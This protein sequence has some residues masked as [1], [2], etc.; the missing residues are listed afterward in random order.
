M[1]QKPDPQPLSARRYRLLLATIFLFLCLLLGAVW[2]V[3]RVIA[4]EGG[5]QEVPVSLESSLQ[6][7]YLADALPTRPSISMALIFEAMRDW[8]PGLDLERRQTAV[9]ASLQTPVP[10]A[11]SFIPTATPLPTATPTATPSPTPTIDFPQNNGSGFAPVDAAENEAT[12]TAAA[13]TIE[14]ELATA[15]AMPTSAEATPSPTATILPLQ[16][17]LP[18]TTATPTAFPTDLPTP[19]PTPT[20]RA[21]SAAPPAT[22]PAATNVPTSTAPTA[23]TNAPIETPTAPTATPLVPTAT[24]NVPTPPPLP[25]S[26]PPPLPTATQ[27]RP[28]PTPTNSAYP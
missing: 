15:V 6:A 13:A 2:F 23:T 7:N 12:S 20:D 8:E 11:A 16:P 14:S 1:I 22:V 5:A 17:T 10:T 25:T 28:E 26:T 27:E 18:A 3:N 19:L 24:P 21:T 4:A 9:L